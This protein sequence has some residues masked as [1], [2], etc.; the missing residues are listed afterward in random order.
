MAE[1]ENNTPEITYQN[2]GYFLQIIDLLQQ[3]LSALSNDAEA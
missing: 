3:I 2:E 1:N